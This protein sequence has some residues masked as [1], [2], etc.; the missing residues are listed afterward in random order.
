MPRSQLNINIDPDLLREL[1]QHAARSGVTLTEFVTTSFE[2]SLSEAKKEKNLEDR[3]DVLEEL[4]G[5]L[6]EE[7]SPL[8]TLAGGTGLTDKRFTDEG[9]RAYSKVAK[10]EFERYSKLKALKSKEALAQLADISLKHKGDLELISQILTGGYEL[11]G[12]DMVKAI[13][14][15][16]NCP[17]MKSLPEWSGDLLPALG[18]AFVDAIEI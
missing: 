4:V 1:K 3:I 13:Q 11:T 9:A 17:M 2:Q 7:R 6:L 10:K 12:D 14:H 16:G 15:T 8:A 18:K 5:S